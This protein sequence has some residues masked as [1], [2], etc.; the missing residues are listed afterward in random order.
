[1]TVY[2]EFCKLFEI[3]H[4]ATTSFLQEH[5]AAERGC[6]VGASW[7][8]VDCLSAS[9][10]ELKAINTS[11]PV[12][13]HLLW[14]RKDVPPLV[15]DPNTWWRDLRMFVEEGNKAMGYREPFFL[16]VAL[17][18]LRSHQAKA[19]VDKVKALKRCADP[20][21]ARACLDWV[22]KT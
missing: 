15:R 3:C 10:E 20:L 1:M 17:P 13:E 19:K 5:I 14:L 21:W 7:H 12:P 4:D 11:L 6:E 16:H 2:R 22:E 9:D 18:I 8:I